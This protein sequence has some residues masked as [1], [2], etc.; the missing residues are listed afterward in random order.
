MNQ[1]NE[2]P[3]VYQVT[4]DH[5]SKPFHLNPAPDAPQN[6][7]GEVEVMVNCQYCQNELIVTL[8]RAIAETGTIFRGGSRKPK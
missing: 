4:C 2:K 6:A 7:K 1:P 3:K 5:C 8:P